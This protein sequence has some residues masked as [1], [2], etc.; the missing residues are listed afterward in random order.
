MCFLKLRLD[1]IV[2][3]VILQI[4]K[5]FDTVSDFSVKPVIRIMLTA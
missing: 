3:Y 5:G 2:L 1:D 4:I